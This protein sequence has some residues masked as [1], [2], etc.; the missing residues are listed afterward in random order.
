MPRRAR[1]WSAVSSA[2][3][4]LKRR[5]LLVPARTHGGAAGY[6]LPD[7]ARRLPDD[8]ARRLHGRPAARSADRWLPTVFS[9]PEEERH[10][11]HL[12]RTQSAPL[13]FGTAAPGVWI[14]PAHLHNETRHTLDRPDPTRY[15]AF[16]PASTP[17]SCRPPRRSR[18]G[19]T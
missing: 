14:A 12:L 11:R 7:A 6:A 16:S 8:G 9:F 4:R 15:V 18:A 2:V 1:Y 17:V 13:G 5:G 10:R 19:G 3:S